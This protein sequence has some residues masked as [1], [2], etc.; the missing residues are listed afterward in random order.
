MRVILA[1][2][3]GSAAGK[4]VAIEPQHPCRVGRSDGAE[5]PIANDGLLSR[6]HFVVECDETTCRVRDLDSTNGTFLNG[7]RI[8]MAEIHDGDVVL[9]GSTAFSLRAVEEQWSV[10]A[11]PDPAPPEVTPGAK[12]AGISTV[13]AMKPYTPPAPPD[14]PASE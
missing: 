7:Q 8:T 10:V 9:A 13:L 6:L 14:D 12:D 3:E 2:T 5:L 11:T 1:V 4:A